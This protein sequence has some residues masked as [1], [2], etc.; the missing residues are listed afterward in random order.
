M[1]L[2][3]CI[4]YFYL[5]SLFFLTSCQSIEIKIPVAD[6]KSPEVIK[7]K[8]RQF[9]I[10]AE[11]T[12][13]LTVTENANQRPLNITNQVTDS[14]VINA[15]FNYGYEDHLVIGAGVNSASGL[16]VQTQFQFLDEV[17]DDVGWSSAVQLS[18]NYNLLNKSGSE[19]N[20]L[21]PG[22]YSYSGSMRALGFNPGIT[23][24]YRF[25][26]YFM[27]YAGISYASISTTTSITQD[28]STDGNDP[29]KSYSQDKSGSSQTLGVGVQV[30]FGK[31]H[32]KPVV[33]WSEIDI[34]HQK[35]TQ[36]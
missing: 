8:V 17:L 32:L 33:Q 29:G 31:F 13:T 16:L 35:K 24:G 34:A 4:S 2:V 23:A 5:L 21:G 19:T 14:S 28:P 15:H 1:K 10:S 6:L 7:E 12:K 36:F 26:K 27:T 18:V 9:S 20:L 3:I 25:N 22:T 30:D 11:P